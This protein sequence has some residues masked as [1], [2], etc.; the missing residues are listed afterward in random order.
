ME[1]YLPADPSLPPLGRNPDFIFE[2]PAVLANLRGHGETRSLKSWVFLTRSPQAS[3]FP[4]FLSARPPGGDECLARESFICL[5]I[6][7]VLYQSIISAPQRPREISR[8]STRSHPAR[9]P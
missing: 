7:E 1:W 3:A 8:S 6:D 5:P 9:P 2:S 4:P